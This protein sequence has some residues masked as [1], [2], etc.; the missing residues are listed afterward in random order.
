MTSRGL[1]QYLIAT[2]LAFPLLIIYEAIVDDPLAWPL[3][4]LSTVA[5]VVG[6]TIVA[7]WI[8]GLILRRVRQQ[9]GPK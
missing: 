6:T 8:A 2:V 3:G 4:I 1:P 7:Y 5:F 9:P